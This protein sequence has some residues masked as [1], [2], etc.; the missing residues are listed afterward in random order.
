MT[1]FNQKIMAA[2]LVS[3]NLMVAPVWAG[4]QKQNDGIAD[5]QQKYEQHTKQL[6]EKLQLTPEQEPAW[7]AYKAKPA[8]METNENKKQRKTQRK[9]EMDAIQSLPAPER[10]A[11]LLAN[12]QKHH[13]EMEEH[14]RAH[15]AKT[16]TFY[17]TLTPAQ[18][19]IFD[20]ET[21]IKFHHK[22]PK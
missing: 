1:F 19:T 11:K 14:F 16:E 22:K 10:E 15:L 4:Q 12:M 5:Y 20:K 21:Q 13:A 18:K 9:A 17:R 7:A 3:S 2:I 8:T 6:K